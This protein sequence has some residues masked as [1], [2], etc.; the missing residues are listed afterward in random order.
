MNRPTRILLIAALGLTTSL[1][2]STLAQAQI[3]WSTNQCIQR[4]GKPVYSTSLGGIPEL[5]FRVGEFVID[6]VIEND[7][8]ISVNFVKRALT[9]EDVSAILILNGKDWILQKS[10]QYYQREGWLTQDGLIECTCDLVV[11]QTDVFMTAVCLVKDEHR[12]LK[13]LEDDMATN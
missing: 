10:T 5:G 13:L 7:K 9:E 3:G 4:L 11:G 1:T 12:L 8:A 2:C 6:V